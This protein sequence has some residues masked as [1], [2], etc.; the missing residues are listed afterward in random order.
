MTITSDG[1]NQTRASAT[2][3]FLGKVGIGTDLPAEQL[4]VG[5]NVQVD[6]SLSLGGDPRSNWPSGAE[7]ALMVSNN[8]SEISGEA[9]KEA[10][11]ANLGL[12]SAATNEA[13][14]FLS[15]TS[16]GSQLTGITAEQVG[17]VSTNAGALLAANNLAEL[18]ATAATARDN[19][20]A[21]STTGNGSQLTG[22]T[23]GQVGALSTTGGVVNGASFF[24]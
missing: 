16:D 22:I 13:S 4:H 12:G 8:L 1:I 11:R 21:L 24:I 5:G 14:V 15:P 10:A 9:N 19:L 2:N 3:V 6:G 20:G 7:G 17:A 18:A 23:A